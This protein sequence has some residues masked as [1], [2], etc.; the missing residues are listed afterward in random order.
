MT[1]DDEVES[2]LDL[3]TIEDLE[4]FSIVQRSQQMVNI[5]CMSR[6][7]GGEDSL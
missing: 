3:S 2:S 6:T 4:D 5:F 1:R 7:V